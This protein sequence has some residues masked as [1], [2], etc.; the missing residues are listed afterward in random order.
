MT[1]AILIVTHNNLHLTKR[2]VSSALR[3]TVPCFVLVVDNASTD[4]TVRWLISRRRRAL[5]EGSHCGVIVPTSP[6]SLAACWNLGLES[7]F[8]AG[9]D[10]V[11]VLNNDVEI[12]PRSY[13]ILASYMDWSPSRE[14]LVSLTAVDRREDLPQ[15]IEEDYKLA[16]FHAMRIP[17]PDFSGFMIRAETYRTVGPFD[18]RYFPAY[19]E[20]TDFHVRMHRAG[21]MA[22]KLPIPFLHHRSSTMA[23]AS[24]EERQMIE[25]GAERN[26]TRFRELYGCVP[27]TPEYA[28]LFDKST[29][30]MGI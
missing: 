23:N 26:R 22:S 16:D 4:S 30:G 19:V 17:H 12:W 8:K 25:I 13:E 1:G 15:F 14:G 11:L 9:R 28:A 10:K 6:L 3:Q 21:V 5:D 29:F 24:P 20:D 27:G 2:A 7:F 18:E